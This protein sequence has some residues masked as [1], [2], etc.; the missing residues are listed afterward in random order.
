[1]PIIQYP[2]IVIICIHTYIHTCDDDDE[3]VYMFL[4]CTSKCVYALND[5][6]YLVRQHCEYMHTYI[7]TYIHTCDDDDESVCMFL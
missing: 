5:A 2:S 4:G 3:S 7:H 6:D 1:M